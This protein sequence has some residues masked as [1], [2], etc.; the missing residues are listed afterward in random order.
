M[1]Q[2]LITGGS[3]GIGLGLA[4]RFLKDGARVIITGRDPEKLAAVHPGLET[5]VNDISQIQQREALAI[6]ID[7]TMP[8]IDM[9]I[10]N[11]GIQ[12]RVA[13]ADDQALWP[14]RQNE[15]DIL[16]A[17]PVHL[18]HLLLPLLLQESKTSTIVNVTSGGAY[19]PQVFAPL[20]SACK[21]AL[22]HYTMSL[23]YSLQNTTCKVTEL[24]PPAVQTGLAG[25]GNNHGVP[26]K[27]FC[28]AIYGALIT[29]KQ[30]EIGYAQTPGLIPQISGKAVAELFEMSAARYPVKMY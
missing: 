20:Y 8:G 7:K 24:I 9:L 29:G 10:N 25:S 3:S 30:S 2:I 17:A 22:H 15:I 16:L 26:L 18:N 11:A 13:L 23:R 5:F 4:E 19:I 12:R 27:E 21:A 14:D 28:D 6:H 1:K